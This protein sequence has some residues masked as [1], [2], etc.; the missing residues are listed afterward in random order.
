MK[1]L[2]SP[3]TPPTHDGS[4]LLRVNNGLFDYWCVG[5]YDTE[6]R[7]WRYVHHH[8]FGAFLFTSDEFTVRGWK[9]LEG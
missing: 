2:T 8:G 5:Q 4:V 6:I 9:E 7:D 1:N 3:E